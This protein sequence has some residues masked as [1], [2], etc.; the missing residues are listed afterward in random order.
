MEYA[1][2]REIYMVKQLLGHKSLKNTDRYQHM[3]KFPHEEYETKRPRTS[4]EEDNLSNAGYVFVRY[5]FKEECP[6]YRR[7]K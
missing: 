2:T 6:I 4:E 3:V 1:K 7:R 5:D